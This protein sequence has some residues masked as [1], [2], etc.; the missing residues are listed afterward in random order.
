LRQF[1]DGGDQDDTR[2]LFKQD[3]SEPQPTQN[4]KDRAVEI[5]K[6]WKIDPVIFDISCKQLEIIRS[7][8]YQG[9][10][11]HAETLRRFFISTAGDVRVLLAAFALRLAEL[12]HSKVSQD[13]ALETIEVYAPLANRLGMGVVKAEFESLTFPIAYPKEYAA[14]RALMQETEKLS[15]IRLEKVYRSL[16][17]YFAKEGIP[18][19]GS[20]YRLKNI[21]SLYKKLKRPD[22]NMD[23]D[24]IHDLLA[25]R[26]ITDTTEN[27][28]RILGL[29]HAKWK[30]VPGK[31]KDYINNPKPNGYRSL[32]TT[33]Y[34]GDTPR[35]TH[36]EVAGGAG[37]GTAEIQIRTTWMH[38]EAEY[39]ITSHV[40]Y[41][42]GGKER[43]GGKWPKNLDWVRELV[44]QAKDAKNKNTFNEAL[45]LD[46]FRD[47]IFVFTPMGD[48]IELPDGATP[49]DFA[50]AIHSD[51]GDHAHAVSI[52][53]KY[54]TLDKKLHA[55]ETVLIETS[56]KAHPTSKWLEMTTTVNARK[57]IRAYL[58]KQ[59]KTK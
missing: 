46:F 43:G 35:P 12:R 58:D 19:L 7:H 47:R 40:A 31:I 50:Y 9:L 25:L 14:T 38:A 20:D 53:G 28:Y 18:I 55:G 10:E 5:L 11:N 32:H 6:G 49:L 39:G 1:N 54:A 48:V 59:K 15:R 56:K 23:I 41:D 29:I 30:P 45:R 26:L 24:K 33:I 27:C 42:E 34:T 37:G 57:R 16:R 13:I 4:I 52:N 36:S 44:T 2:A 3:M 17:K 51:L 8:S 21:Y 22:K